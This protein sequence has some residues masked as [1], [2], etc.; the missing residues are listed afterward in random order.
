M[1]STDWTH[2]NKKCF[3]HYKVYWNFVVECEKKHKKSKRCEYFCTVDCLWTHCLNFCSRLWSGVPNTLWILA[4]WSNSLAPGK[5]GCRLEHTHWVT[6][7]PPGHTPGT[8][9]HVSSPQDLKE[10]AA[11]AP[12]V[13][14]LGVVAVGQEALRRPVPTRGDVLS[15]RR[16]GVHTATWAEVAQL[17]NVL[18][19]LRRKSVTCFLKFD[20]GFDTPVLKCWGHLMSF[21]RS[22][23]KT[24]RCN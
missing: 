23:E 7:V 3:M 16:L 1:P 8:G 24:K 11:G 13:H 2:R 22:A 5:R 20:S 17:Q 9:R 4:T 12:D 10:D 14:L 6:P 15:V 21:Y 18:L 19:Q